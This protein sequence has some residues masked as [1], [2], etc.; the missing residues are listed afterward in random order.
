MSAAVLA[1][2][3]L[4]AAPS[5]ANPGNRGGTLPG[6]TTL[7]VSPVDRLVDGQTVT[8]T[9]TGLIPMQ[10]FTLEECAAVVTS[11]NDCDP[12][13]AL[14]STINTSGDYTITTSIRATITTPNQ[15]RIGCDAGTTCSIAAWEDNLQA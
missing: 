8:V 11:S 13:T 5:I 10:P 4:T 14:H 2:A 7:A 1:G 6:V 9:G 3:A 15:G 12:T